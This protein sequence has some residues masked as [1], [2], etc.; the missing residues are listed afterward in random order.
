VCVLISLA[1][2]TDSLLQHTHLSSTA[3][4]CRLPC[5]E[6]SREMAEPN[7]SS[8]QFF[9][10]ATPRQ[11]IYILSHY[12]EVLQLHAVKT[13]GAKKNGPEELVKLDT[14]YQETLPKIIQSR[15][16]PHV[17]HEELVQ[18]TKWKLSRGKSRAR[19]LDLVRIN[20][21]LAVKQTTQKAFRKLPKDLFSAINA[22]TNLKGIGPQTASAVLCAGYPDKCPY[23]ADESMLATPGVEATD[24]TLNEFVN[25]ATQIIACAKKLQESDPESNWTPHKV[26]MT[27]WVHYLAKDLK[28]SILTNLPLA[29]GELSASAILPNSTITTINSNNIDHHRD[30]DDEDSLS[31]HPAKR[32]RG[33]ED[34]GDGD[35]ATATASEEDNSNE[36][37]N[38]T[39]INNG[40]LEGEDDNS[41]SNSSHHVIHT[42][43]KLQHT[44][45]ENSSEVVSEN[46]ESRDSEIVESSGVEDGKHEEMD[47]NNSES[48]DSLVVDSTSTII[49]QKIGLV[50]PT[51]N[52]NGI[53]ST[54]TVS[55]EDSNSNVS[56]ENSF[57]S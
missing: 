21:E 25:Y 22:L 20:T 15:K 11:W 56:V 36:G 50:I 48:R 3:A 41:R 5:V 37:K 46:S 13:R 27:L 2:T 23:M 38:C 31:P 33:G 17:T 55:N 52:G 57:E 45:N 40:K 10:K 1:L 28:S 42:N 29:N 43:D 34:N 12:K 7:D 44:T 4:V 6:K 9:Q 14:W 39:T 24:Y 30:E 8:L 18:I 51:T 47:S 49:P 35:H 26:E 16:D 54:C 19:I 32:R 53:G